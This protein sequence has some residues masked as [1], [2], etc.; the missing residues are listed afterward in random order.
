MSERGNPKWSKGKSGN[1]RGRPKKDETRSELL[2][3]LDRA[4]KRHDKKFIDYYVE[5]AY[6]DKGVAQDLASKLWPDLK[7]IEVAGSAE[8]P[9]RLIIDLPRP[10]DSK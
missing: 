4:A 10:P 2:L 9:L 5:L 6:E 7:A 1:P 3:A 8:S